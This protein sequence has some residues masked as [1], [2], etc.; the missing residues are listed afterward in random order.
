[1]RK[2]LFIQ[3]IVKD[4]KSLLWSSVEAEL[5]TFK[6][7]IAKLLDVSGI[8]NIKYRT[9]QHGSILWPIL[10]MLIKWDS[11]LVSSAHI[12]LKPPYPY[13]CKNVC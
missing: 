10:F 11:G 12:P 3:K 6:A 7:E 2:T 8:M 13:I 4:W 5:F 9:I 1:M